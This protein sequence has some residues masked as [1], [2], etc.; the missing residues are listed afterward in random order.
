MGNP[1]GITPDGAGG[2]WIPVAWAGGGTILRY[3]MPVKERDHRRRIGSG[4]ACGHAS[5][6]TVC[7]HGGGWPDVPPCPA[8]MGWSGGGLAW[9]QGPDDGF[10][11]VAG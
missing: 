1:F 4:F 11:A 3:A 7:D 5:F 8:I 10:F 2:L 9:R 6:V